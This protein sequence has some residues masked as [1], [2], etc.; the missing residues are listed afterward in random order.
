M[1]H[2]ILIL[3]VIFLFCSTAGYLGGWLYDISTPQQ[4]LGNVRGATSTGFFVGGG[5]SIAIATSSTSFDFA[6]FKDTNLMSTTVPATAA[7]ST[8][9]M[10]ASGTPGACLILEDADNAGFTYCNVNNGTMT[11][12]T[13]NLCK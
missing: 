8:L 9:F 6:I 1:K 2:S 11:C 13:N 10:A 12:S 4:M 5:E 3:I 7:S